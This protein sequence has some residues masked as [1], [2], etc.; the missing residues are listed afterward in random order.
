MGEKPSPLAQKREIKSVK[1]EITPFSAMKGDFGE[2][3]EMVESLE[4]DSKVNPR[5]SPIRRDSGT[6]IME[7]SRMFF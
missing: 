3:K 2:I 4:I 5:I 1:K 7:N 6:K